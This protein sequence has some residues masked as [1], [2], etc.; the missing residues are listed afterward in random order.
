METTMHSLTK[1][2]AIVTGS[3]S[4]SIGLAYARAFA[5]TG[6]NIV[7]HGFGMSAPIEK[8]RSAI[9]TEFNVKAVAGIQFVSPKSVGG[10]TMHKFFLAVILL[11]VT[12][13]NGA[14]AHSGTDQEEQACTHDVQRFCRKLMDQGDLRKL[15]K[16]GAGRVDNRCLLPDQQM[17]GDQQGSRPE[18]WRSWP[19]SRI[20]VQS[21]LPP[22]ATF[23]SITGNSE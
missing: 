5:R 23:W 11:S 10:N 15:C 8:E 7:L 20:I 3:T 9:E 14:L 12:A 16:A 19:V 6:A 18:P 2:A 22:A 17:L 13:S 1:K 4:G 21:F